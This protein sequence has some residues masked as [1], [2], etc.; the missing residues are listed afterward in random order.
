MGRNASMDDR[1]NSG[2]YYDAMKMRDS[3]LNPS[4]DAS[5]YKSKDNV[6]A[7]FNSIGEASPYKSQGNVEASFNLNVVQQP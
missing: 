1:L 5:P 2:N 7:S 3:S 6:E 4:G